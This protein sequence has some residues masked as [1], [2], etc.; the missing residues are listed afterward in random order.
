MGSPFPQTVAR[1]RDP[2]AS[3]SASAGHVSGRPPVVD[4]AGLMDGKLGAH[5]T[6]IERESVPGGAP[7]AQRL[8]MRLGDEVFG[9]ATVTQA[10]PRSAVA[11]LVRIVDLRLVLDP[12]PDSPMASLER[13]ISACVRHVG[14]GAEGLWDVL[15]VRSPTHGDIVGAAAWQFA[16]MMDYG[17]DMLP[18]SSDEIQLRIRVPGRRAALAHFLMSAPHANGLATWARSLAHRVRRRASVARTARERLPEVHMILELPPAVSSLA[19]PPG[20]GFEEISR[21]AVLAHPRRYASYGIDADVRLDRG[22]RCFASHLD[23]RVI[24]RMWVSTNARFIRQRSERL[25][26]LPRAAYVYDSFTEPAWRGRSIRGASLRWLAAILAEEADRI[27]LSVDAD[28]LASI[29]AAK[30]AGFRSIDA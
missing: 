10:H 22:D 30:K 17:C 6:L 13:A 21:A 28:N 12:S 26:A 24:F 4:Q 1:L 11:R 14:I 20:V 23:G 25:G 5:T 15:I 29:R 8:V 27:V 9:R 7:G 3:S 18:R 2:D 19:P 16:T